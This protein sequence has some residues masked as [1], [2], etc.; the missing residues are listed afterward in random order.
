MRAVPTHCF[1]TEGEDITNP[2]RGS[3]I[4]EFGI[5]HKNWYPHH[6]L[7]G[8]SPQISSPGTPPQMLQGCQIPILFPPVLQQIVNPFLFHGVELVLVQ[9]VQDTQICASMHF[10]CVYFSLLDDL[11]RRVHKSSSLMEDLLATFRL[12]LDRLRLARA[13]SH[14]TMR[15]GNSIL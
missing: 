11:P 3:R 12:C 2:D 5:H 1:R 6:P 4:L 14:L 10:F 8:E 13:V 7:A 15:S 9:H